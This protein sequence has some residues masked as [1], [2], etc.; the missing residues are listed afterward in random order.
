M[1]LDFSEHVNDEQWLQI[2]KSIKS[3]L[4]IG[5]RLYMHTPNANFFLEIMKNRNFI[6]K[7]FPEHI[8]V[9]SAKQ[10]QLLLEKVGYKVKE[11]KFIPHYNFLKYI[12]WFSF[13]PGLG[14][15][16]KARIFIVAVRN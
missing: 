6:F 5:G 3:S 7:Q 4:K 10:N 13:I 11:T 12:H 15:Y 2:L 16:F 1:A 9:R 14:S 8:A